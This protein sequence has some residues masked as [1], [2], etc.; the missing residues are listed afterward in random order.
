MKTLVLAVC[1][2]AIPARVLCQEPVHRPVSSRM[3]ANLLA[4]LN[5]SLQQLAATVAPAVVQIEST[6]FGAVEDEEG[7][8]AAAVLVRQRA[9]GAGV[10][11]D[12]D[13]YIMTNAHVVEGAHRIRVTLSM[14]GK[15]QRLDAKVV[16]VERQA[17]LALL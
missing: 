2:A 15:F 4:Q 14:A 11:V 5:D 9:I 17:D 7:K 13:G 6:G 1:V 10:L 12:A 8:T 3:P 16:G